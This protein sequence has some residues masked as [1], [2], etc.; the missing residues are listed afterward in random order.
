VSSIFRGTLISIAAFILMACTGENPGPL[1]GTWATTKP[2]PVTVSFRSGE[3][4]AMGRTKKV[5][6]KN[7]GN[8]VLVTYKDG[9]AKGTSYRYTVV[10]ANTIRSDS[11]TFRRVR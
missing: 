1:E 5:S 8:E 10:D 6:Y 2:I 9:T 4:E 11:G 7:N 3:V